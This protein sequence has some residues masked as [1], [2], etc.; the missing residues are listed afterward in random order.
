M[1][2]IP[3]VLNIV[4]L[5]LRHFYESLLY[6]KEQKITMILFFSGILGQHNSLLYNNN[7]VLLLVST[8]GYLHGGCQIYPCLPGICCEY[9]V[10]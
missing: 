9:L 5:K 6:V 2:T 8:R 1:S 4:L 3:N 7:N 10:G